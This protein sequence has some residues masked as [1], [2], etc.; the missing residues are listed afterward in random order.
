MISSNIFYLTFLSVSC[1]SFVRAPLTPQQTIEIGTFWNSELADLHDAL[2]A[3]PQSTLD[4]YF[5]D[6]ILIFQNTLGPYLDNL[7]EAVLNGEEDA[8][9]PGQ[10][11]TRALDGLPNLV[12]LIKYSNV[13]ILNNLE[14][15]FLALYP[16]SIG[17]ESI[18]GIINNENVSDVW[19]NYI[20]YRTDLVALPLQS[21][22]LYIAIL[23]S[24][25][26][27]MLDLIPQNHRL[28]ARLVERLEIYQRM[29]ISLHSEMARYMRIQTLRP[30][31]KTFKD[32]KKELKK[33]AQGVMREDVRTMKIEDHAVNIAHAILPMIAIY[34]RPAA[35]PATP[36][37]PGDPATLG[38]EILINLF[39]TQWT[40]RRLIGQTVNM[41]VSRPRW[42]QRLL[43]SLETELKEIENRAGAWSSWME[44]IREP[45]LNRA[46]DLL[47]REIGGTS[48]TKYIKPDAL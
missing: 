16:V 39:K 25:N 21:Y 8:P 37:I 5:S 19:N 1:M 40:V 18:L 30:Y 47:N 23:F 33:I 7:P 6:C 44:K 3:V 15:Q 12:Y 20:R 28:D 36:T 42:I 38:T 46:F 41:N 9:S 22:I 2:Q 45:I 11:L 24:M 4:A 26:R 43:E 14:G 17:S 10:H 27:T 34:G 31:S 32:F 29:I 13:C 48:G 35:R